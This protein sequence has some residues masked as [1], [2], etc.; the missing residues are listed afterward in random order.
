MGRNLV[1]LV[2]ILGAIGLIV[3]ISGCTSSNSTNTYNGSQM[4]FQYPNSWSVI[5]ES[6]NWVQFKASE[7][8]VRVWNYAKDSG[9]LGSFT[10]SDNETVGDKKYT[11]MVTGGL[12][13]YAFQGNNSDLFIIASKGNDEGVKQ[14]IETIQ[15][16]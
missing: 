12:T 14:I 3:G 6:I 16:K 11:K 7:G 5:N 4:S 15:F 2:T 13:S 9:Q 10:F 1:S 8:E